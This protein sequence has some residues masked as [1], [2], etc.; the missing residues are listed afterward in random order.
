MNKE[1]LKELAATL[2]GIADGKA[3]ETQFSDK[4]GWADYLFGDPLQAV[5]FGHTIRLKPWSLPPPPDGMQWH[6]D[7]WTEEMLPDGWRPHL[8]GEVDNG[9]EEFLL[10]GEWRKGYYGS[11]VPTVASDHHRRTKAPLSQRPGPFLE[12]KAAHA[13]GKKLQHRFPGESKWWDCSVTDTSQDP[14]CFIFPPECYRIKP[15]QQKVPLGPD[16]VPP[17]T[18]FRFH[19]HDDNHHYLPTLVAGSKDGVYFT[20]TT[21]FRRDWSYLMENATINRSIPLTGKWNPEAWE[22]CYKLIDTP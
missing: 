7:D 4:S 5:A 18:V 17:G 6:R 19:G 12:L 9:D 21:H 8:L 3:W 16:D 15:E 13:A 2:N 22:P 20:D 1:E 10:S 14:Y 11:S